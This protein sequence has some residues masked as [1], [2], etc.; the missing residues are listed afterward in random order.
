MKSLARLF[1]VLTLLNAIWGPVNLTVLAARN[2]GFTATGIGLVR[3]FGIAVLLAILV[4]LPIAR[5]KMNLVAP[6]RPDAVYAVAI[7]LLLTGPAHLMYY[8]AI[9][10]T[11]PTAG[12][13]FN[14]TGPLW[15]ALFAGL[16]L[17]ERIDG[18][19]WLALLLGAVGS[20]VVMLGFS[21]RSIG[22]NS[23]WNALY[24][25]GVVLESLAAV[26]L[27]GIMRRSSGLTVLAVE[28]WGIA[29]AFAIASLAA[30]A[31]FPAHAP[32]LGLQW[33]SLAYLIVLAGAFCFGAWSTI[34]EKT[35]LSLMV[36]TLALQ[37]LFGAVAAH[38]AIREVLAT[39]T[40]IGA[41]FVVSGLIVAAIDAGRR[42]G[43]DLARL[44]G[45]K[46]A[47]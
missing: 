45:D 31:V 1:L 38:F 35:P 4:R 16:L 32:V 9:R 46:V 6:N 2:A 23:I 44:G 13:V 17:G 18:W 29:G 36:I 22:G 39:K 34:V 25:T 3:W 19:R 27:A 11:S 14:A 37:P 10:F 8:C 5:R 33:W 15:V 41:L 7:G 20:Y 42:R 40:V 28:T 43:G 26:L 24:L 21:A 12:T 30:P 47:D